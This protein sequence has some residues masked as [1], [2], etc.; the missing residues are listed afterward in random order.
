MAIP[1]PGQCSLLFIDP[2]TVFRRQAFF[3]ERRDLLAQFRRRHVVAHLRVQ[4]HRA[5]INVERAHEHLAPVQHHGL[6]VQAGPGAPLEQ[7]YLTVQGTGVGFQ[8]V[9]LHTR[10]QQ[11]IP[12][13]GIGTVGG[14]H[15]IGGQAVGEHR[16]AATPLFH[17]RQF[18][19]KGIA[20]NKVAGLHQ[21]LLMVVPGQQVGELIAHQRLLNPGGLVRAVEQQ[22]RMGLHTLAIL[23]RQV[24]GE[25]GFVLGKQVGIVPQ[26]AA[27]LPQ[28]LPDSIRR[29]FPVT[30]QGLHGHGQ[31]AVPV[32]VKGGLGIGN[33]G[34]AGVQVQITKIGGRIH[35]KIMIGNIATAHDCP[36]AIHDP[37]LVMHAVIQQRRMVQPLQE[38][39][40]ATMEGVEKT[41]LDIGV[42]VQCRPLHIPAQLIGVIQQHAHF[43]PPARRFQH[44]VDQQLA[45]GVVIPDVILH[46][47]GS[48]GQTDQGDTQGER[49]VAVRHQRQG[50]QCRRA[51]LRTHNVPSPFTHTAPLPLL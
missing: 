21:Q 11:A 25:E 45:G 9:Q 4:M 2:I 48:P 19:H 6:G 33:D 20:G 39:L 28:P 35:P 50:G 15:I 32:A 44:P 27:P 13:P 1:G 46:I 30:T 31:R 43:H 51:G 29:R 49:L 47:Q 42:R 12:V 22:H 17:L 7:P 38:V 40:V 3:D 34:T 41:H 26:G 14:N 10:L 16:R 8:F 18:R 37:G 5:R 24:F 36:F 23:G